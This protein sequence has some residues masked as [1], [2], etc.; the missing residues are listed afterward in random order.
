MCV[1]TYLAPAPRG[2]AEVN[3]LRDS[4]EE[5]KLLIKLEQLEGAPRSETD[6]HLCMNN[7]LSTHVTGGRVLISNVESRCVHMWQRMFSADE[8]PHDARPRHSADVVRGERRAGKHNT[9]IQNET[10]PV[11]PM[12]VSGQQVDT[13][14]RR[15]RGTLAWC[16]RDPHSGPYVP[17]S[18]LFLLLYVSKFKVLRTSLAFL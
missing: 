4:F 14:S 5:A 12:R 10:F 3:S 16:A 18:R 17:F 8:S 2:R 7:P 1:G 9:T 6:L 11:S 15:R 13:D